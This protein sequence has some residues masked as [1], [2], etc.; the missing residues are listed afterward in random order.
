MV[1]MI[2]GHN[3]EPSA[4]NSSARP[5]L[6]RN[7]RLPSAPAGWSAHDEELTSRRVG[8]RYST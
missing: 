2:R 8:L 3:P 7:G 5:D 1:E 6:G 4:G